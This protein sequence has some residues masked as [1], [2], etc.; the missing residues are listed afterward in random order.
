MVQKTSL[1]HSKAHNPLLLHLHILIPRCWCRYGGL[2]SRSRSSYALSVLGNDGLEE[3][4][5]SL[6]FEDSERAG[7]GDALLVLAGGA[8]DAD[9]GVVDREL[10]VLLQ[11]FPERVK[12]VSDEVFK[13]AFS[14]AS[15]RRTI[16]S[17]SYGF[18]EE[19]RGELT[20]HETLVMLLQIRLCAL[21]PRSDRH[22]VVLIRV[23]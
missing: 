19:G 12:A 5:Y 2:S 11:G 17:D 6:V 1:H 23:S 13:V 15:Q 4:L 22:G 16:R 7:W 18:G 3:R 14:D 21:T 8:D 10:F 9:G 20:I